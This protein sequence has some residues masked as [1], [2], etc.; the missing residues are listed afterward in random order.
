[1]KRP[2]CKMHY[3]RILRH[4]TPGGVDSR[5]RQEKKLRDRR[6]REL[7]AR[8]DKWKHFYGD[9]WRIRRIT[10][11]IASL[12]NTRAWIAQHKNASGPRAGAHPETVHDNTVRSWHERGWIHLDKIDEVTYEVTWLGG[13]HG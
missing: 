6:G 10:L 7:A 12:G 2:L 5:W 3:T 8:L 4:G 1:M 13:Y 11:A 9:V